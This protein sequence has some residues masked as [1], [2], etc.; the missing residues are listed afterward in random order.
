MGSDGVRYVDALYVE[1]VHSGGHRHCLVFSFNGILE[2]T[3]FAS[4]VV[5]TEQLCRVCGFVFPFAECVLDDLHVVSS[6]GED[7]VFVLGAIQ[8]NL[9]QFVVESL[10]YILKL[11]GCLIHGVHMGVSDVRDREVVNVDLY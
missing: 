1:D 6:V 5:D 4:S 2:V 11:I 10:C 9:S 3:S 8:V 7:L